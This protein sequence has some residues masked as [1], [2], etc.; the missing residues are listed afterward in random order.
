MA[1]DAPGLFTAIAT[2]ER[3][4]GKIYLD[5]LRNARGATAIAPYSTRARPGAPVAL[6]VAWDE[7]AGLASAAAFT[8][9]AV[10]R[11]LASGAPDPWERINA[12]AGVLPAHT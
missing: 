8:V 4:K 6:P 7:L 5:Y 12:A 2:K 9:P 1:A 10:L 3:R 11:R